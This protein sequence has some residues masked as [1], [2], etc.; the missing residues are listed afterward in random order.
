MGLYS[1][2][3]IFYSKQNWQMPTQVSLTSFAHQSPRKETDACTN[4]CCRWRQRCQSSVPS[5]GQQQ[6]WPGPQ[7]A[8][9]RSL[10]LEL[11]KTEMLPACVRWT[12]EA[13]LK[14]LTCAFGD[15]NVPGSNER[16][17]PDSNTLGCLKRRPPGDTCHFS[18]SVLLGM[19][20][21]GWGGAFVPTLARGFLAHHPGTQT[22]GHRVSTDKCQGLG[23][24]LFL[25]EQT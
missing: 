22:T 4:L 1:A 15:I 20:P 9:D 24:V 25:L 21:R 8:R 16:N 10:S 23:M 17:Y 5:L 2:R 13:W 18:G 12:Q 7:E 11:S 6:P 19:K 3:C 14:R